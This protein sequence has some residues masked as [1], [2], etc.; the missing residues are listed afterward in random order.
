[1][2]DWTESLRLP[3]FRQMLPN[4]PL[5]N[6]TFDM[7]S[8]R[9]PGSLQGISGGVGLGAGHRRKS[10]ACGQISKSLTT[11]PKDDNIRIGD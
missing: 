9:L 7:E 6:Q 8:T 1:M 2:N 4:L 5:I 3:T 10:L 11:V